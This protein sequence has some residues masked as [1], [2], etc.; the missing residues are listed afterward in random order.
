MSLEEKLRGWTGPS[1]VSEQDKQ[2]RTERMVREAI[3]ACPAF[4]GCSY[5]VYAKGS[6]PNNTNVRADSDVDIAVECTEVIYWQQESDGAAPPSTS[7]SGPWTPSKLRTE[8]EG[9]LRTKFPGQIDA[10][11]LIAI[12]V[13]SSTARVDADVVP[14]FS[15]LYYFT[16]GSTRAG[17]RVFKKNGQCF[18]N[19]AQAQLDKGQ[20]KNKATR[21]RFK[22]GVRILKR[23]E[24][25]M[26]SDKVHR[27]VPSFFVECLVY[28]CPNRL[29][30]ASS[31]TERVKNILVHIW[32]ATQGDDEPAT[33]RWVEVNECKWLFGPHQKW[34][35]ADGRDFAYAAWNYLGYAK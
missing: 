23:V 33:G 6:Y 22:E 32:D 20:A 9:A 19:Y 35:R 7:Y 29:F 31:W 25:A 13:H 3:Q 16:G 26:L 30:A 4:Q 34:T 10:T 8:V 27:E 5:R 15:Y 18:E 14:S 11:G 28:N 17:T 2:E 21:L 1:S 12:E 24:N